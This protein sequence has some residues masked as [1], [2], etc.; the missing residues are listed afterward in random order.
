[1]TTSPHPPLLPFS[2]SPSSP[3]PVPSLSFHHRRVTAD[4]LDKLDRIFTAGL[5]GKPG[6]RTQIGFEPTLHCSLHSN[7]LPSAPSPSRPPS[8]LDDA[9]SKPLSPQSSSADGIR[10]FLPTT[11]PSFLRA[12]EKEP[13]TSKDVEPSP[14]VSAVRPSLSFLHP[15]PSPAPPPSHTVLSPS[16]ITPSIPHLD[17]PPV[18]TSSTSAQ[19]SP[20]P[21]T[22]LAEADAEADAGAPNPQQRNTLLHYWSASSSLTRTS[23]LLKADDDPTPEVEI[24]DSDPER[25]AKATGGRG[26]LTG[27]KRKATQSGGR[28]EGR[29]REMLEKREGEVKELERKVESLHHQLKE[30]EKT[31]QRALEALHEQSADRERSVTGEQERYRQKVQHQLLPIIREAALLRRAEWERQLIIDQHEVGRMVSLTNGL[32]VTEHWMES[33]KVKDLHRRIKAL[34]EEEVKVTEDRQRN[35][36]KAASLKMRQKRAEGSKDPTPTPIAPAPTDDG[37]ARPAPVELVDDDFFSVRLRELRT[38]M[39]E[40]MDRL[41][42][43]HTKKAQVVRQQKLKADELN[44]RF[45]IGEVLHGDRYLLTELLGKGGFSEVFKAYD[46]YELRYVAIKIHRLNSQWSTE[47]RQSYIKH[48]EREYNIHR[49]LEHAAVVKLLDSFP[50]TE[51]SADSEAKGGGGGGV[52]DHYGFATVLEYCNGLDLDYRLKQRGTLS[53]RES[54]VIIRQLFRALLYFSQHSARRII[55]YDLKPA[56]LLFHDHHLKITDFGLSKVMS[57]ADA[58]AT[59]MELTS[60]G[61]GTYWYLPPE[62]FLDHS[63]DPT[64]PSTSTPEKASTPMISS[65]VDI[66]SAGV[67]LYQMLMGRK[68]FGHGLSP[69]AIVRDGIMRNADSHSLD[70]KGFGGS[71]VTMSF[72]QKCLHRD[73]ACRPDIHGVFEDPFFTTGFREEGGATGKRKRNE[74]GK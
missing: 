25:R 74:A 38:E 7:S 10:F 54:R 66:F 3:S 4:R 67:I 15:P 43:L 2:T 55:H 60:Q 62:C 69:Q 48:A 72:V 59:S 28:E 71:Q 30:Q 49:G 26:S 35:K 56:N 34:Q 24:L 19:P 27:N 52:D 61:A 1:M 14:S 65:K 8:A 53:E 21:P 13:A 20:T 5:G 32:S 47:R 42:L 29:T 46:L 18:L 22:S 51:R 70:W 16:P 50:L 36:R 63:S 6:V 64:I 58:D 17:L 39:G 12:E 9:L 23:S 31:S 33:D 57:E 41:T 44:S 40:L 11:L 68:P 45:T 73:P 37:F